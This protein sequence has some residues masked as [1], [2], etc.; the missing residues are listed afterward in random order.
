M[1]WQRLMAWRQQ[2]LPV[3][4]V[5]IACNK[6]GG[7][8][9]V[10]VVNLGESVVK[11]LKL[12]VGDVMDVHRGTHNDRGLVKFTK[13]GSDRKLRK[14]QWRPGTLQ[15]QFPGHQWGVDKHYR[16]TPCKHAVDGTGN[17]VITGPAWL[18]G[19]ADD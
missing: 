9:W 3:D 18:R 4:G 10:L 11:D 14:G 19:G 17:L 6:S 1:A 16:P 12:K 2:V 5:T 7:K 8:S 15:L 13:S